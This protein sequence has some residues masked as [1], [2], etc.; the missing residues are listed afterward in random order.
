MKRRG[1]MMSFFLGIL[2]TGVTAAHGQDESDPVRVLFLSKSSGF[3]HGVIKRENNQLSPVEKIM[4]EW[5]DKYNM[6]VVTTKDAG[7]ISAP[8]L[9][10]YDVLMLYT[11]GDLTQRGTDGYAPMPESGK[12]DLMDWLKTGGGIVGS[13]TSTDTFHN[14]EEYNK[15]IGGQFATHGAQQEAVLMVEK[16]PITEG[17]PEE[18]T[19]Y[20]EWY[21]FKNLTNTFQPIMWLKSA[22][23]NE[24]VYQQVE[25]YPFAWVE[26]V[27][28]G[29]VY[30]NA[31]GHR[32]DIWQNEHYEKMMIN[33]IRWA[34][35]RIGN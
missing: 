32:L 14:W 22:D 26:K 20:D 30:Q 10:N 17:L 2:M 15:V 34:A 19:L 24:D 1:W 8:V 11:T 27:G 33:G 23:M 12:Q 35:G 6:E 16:H 4:L 25:K 18:W 31:Q 28:E 13:H 21:F 3:E 7:M 29:R 9:E 5:A